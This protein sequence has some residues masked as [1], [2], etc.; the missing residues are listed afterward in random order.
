MI[1]CSSS[2]ASSTPATS[3]N[4]TFFCAEEESF[5]VQAKARVGSAE[6]VRRALASDEITVIRATHYHQYDT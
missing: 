3:R 6:A 1:S 5:E 2:F 4:V